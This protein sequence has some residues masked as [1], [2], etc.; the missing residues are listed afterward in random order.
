MTRS[1][2][3]ILLLQWI[4]IEASAQTAFGFRTGATHS[5]INIDKPLGSVVIEPAY[6]WTGN[7]TIGQ[8]INKSIGLWAVPTLTEKNHSEKGTDISKGVITTY[9]NM[10]IQLPILLSYE[11]AINSFYPSIKGGLYGSYW[12]SG[13]NIGL[14]PDI[15]STTGT[16]QPGGSV[17][18]Q[19]RLVKFNNKR[20]FSSIDRR[21]ELGAL[22]TAGIGYK[23]KTA[24][25]ITLECDYAHAF[26]SM[27][28]VQDLN[29]T[30][31]YNRSAS[32]SL[33]LIF[34]LGGK[35]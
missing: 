25:K 11:L 7:I 34:E 32:L 26:S 28:K 12:L 18:E 19:I 4:L 22:I 8:R 16:I 20:N 27:T 3:L 21:V 33:G 31:R 2:I 1:F 5:W 30:R 13:R 10:Y 23:I 35:Q 6:G 15:F 24:Y 9:K 29:N 14:I 17:I